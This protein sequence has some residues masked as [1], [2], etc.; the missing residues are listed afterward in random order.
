MHS[1][2]NGRLKSTKSFSVSMRSIS[3]SL[4]SNASRPRLTVGE[5]KVASRGS[6]G[7][8]NSFSRTSSSGPSCSTGSIKAGLTTFFWFS[9]LVTLVITASLHPNASLG[10]VACSS[11][12]AYTDASTGSYRG[13]SN[14]SSNASLSNASSKSSVRSRESSLSRESR[15][16]PS[17]PLNL[18]SGASSV[19]GEA[20]RTLGSLPSGSE[21]DDAD[22]ICVQV[23][24][25]ST[26][27]GDDWMSR[28]DC[29]GIDETTA[30][31]LSR[32]G[33]IT[34]SFPTGV[35]HDSFSDPSFF[36]LF[37]VGSLCGLMMFSGRFV[38]LFADL[39][40][41]LFSGL[42]TSLF[43]GLFAGLF[44][45]LFAGLFAD[46]FADLLVDLFARVSV[47]ST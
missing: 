29:G 32:L 42:F 2:S 20:A 35:Q 3:S 23:S 45:G 13:S 31:D 12:E 27:R 38:D 14:E 4:S 15:S 44:S 33:S 36:N 22:E 9:L 16:L 46:L 34:G 1:N 40:V 11:T 43:A 41:C 6:K 17:L 37:V 24:G 30:T 5:S 28:T 7:S 18:S 19:S 39:F 21:N 26:H 25:V 10:L 47:R 8:A